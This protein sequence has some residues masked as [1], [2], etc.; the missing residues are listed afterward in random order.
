MDILN[1]IFGDMNCFTIIVSLIS[2]ATTLLGLYALGE[3]YKSGFMLYNISL[4]CQ[5]VLFYTNRF[6]I[7]QLLVL[8]IFNFRN[9]AKWGKKNR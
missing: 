2:L 6:I 8:M 3:K 9:F 1:F 4:A 7:I 5:M